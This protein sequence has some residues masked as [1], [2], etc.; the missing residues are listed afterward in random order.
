ML[1]LELQSHLKVAK[2]SAIITSTETFG[3]LEVE[4]EA[5]QIGTAMAMV[6][7]LTR[8]SKT[9]NNSINNMEQVLQVPK[10]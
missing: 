10:A 9:A 5:L 8:I 2:I 1:G 3:K 7:C 6:I 4:L